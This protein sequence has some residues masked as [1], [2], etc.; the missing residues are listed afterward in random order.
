MTQNDTPASE[1]LK[2][3]PASIRTAEELRNELAARLLNAGAVTIDASTVER[4][5]TASLQLLTAFVREM[6]AASRPVEWL[7]RSDAL[8]RAATVL[9]LSAALGLGTSNT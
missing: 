9:G 7:G 3:G 4:I 6:R 8:E 5:D 1:P 2:L